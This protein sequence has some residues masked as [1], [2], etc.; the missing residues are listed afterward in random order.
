MPIFIN[1]NLGYFLRFNRLLW[2]FTFLR[3]ER[4]ALQLKN[5]KLTFD[6]LSAAKMHIGLIFS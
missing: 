3:F 5:L 1:Y 2:S 6:I 4:Q